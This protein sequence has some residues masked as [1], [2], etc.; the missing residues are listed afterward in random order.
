MNAKR[1]SQ[2]R[3]LGPVCEQDLRAVGIETE[4]DLQRIGVKEAFMRILIG[5]RRDGRNV[6]ACTSTYLYALHGALHDCDWRS[7]PDDVKRDYREFVAELRA[8]GALSN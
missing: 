2:L 7:L 4:A 5:R 6:K 1:I 3:N 8:S